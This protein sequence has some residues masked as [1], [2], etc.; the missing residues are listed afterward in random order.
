MEQIVSSQ[1]LILFHIH[2]DFKFPFLVPEAD[3]VA[4]E[5]VHS[6]P[7]LSSPL[8][9]LDIGPTQWS[10][11]LRKSWISLLRLPFWLPQPPL[12]GQKSLMI[13][14][15][16]QNDHLKFKLF[17]EH[18]FG[19]MSAHRSFSLCSLTSGHAASSHKSYTP[20]PGNNNLN[21]FILCLF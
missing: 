4:L 12:A 1:N 18:L 8:C 13:F 20:G 11:F 6:V 9:S 5:R 15:E 16:S 21:V 14:P 3:S 7:F 2:S 17:T 19:E 10:T